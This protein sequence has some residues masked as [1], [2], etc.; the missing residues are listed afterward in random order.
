MKRASSASVVAADL[1]AIDV[2]H[3]RNS[4]TG[5]GRFRH[6]IAPGGRFGMASIE[7]RAR[8]EGARMGLG[9]RA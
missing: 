8:F 7:A 5:C 4:C 1:P 3:L 6:A 2:G 9:E